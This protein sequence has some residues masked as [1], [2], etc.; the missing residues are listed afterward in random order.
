MRKRFEQQTTLDAIPIPDVRIDMKSRDQFPKLLAGLLHIFITPELNEAVFAIL[1]EKILGEK[2]KTGRLGMSLWELF[3][4]GTVRLNL[5][6][7]Y[8]RLHDLSNN[9][10]SLRGLMGVETRK[11]FEDG[12]YYELQNLK[13]NLRLL[14][15]ET[16]GRINEVIVKAGHRLKKKRLDKIVKSLI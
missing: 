9:H 4:L 14:D 3:V 11:V 6:I 5:N 1:E 15:E 13:D 2:K 12:K 7:D 16:L 10:Q 8:D